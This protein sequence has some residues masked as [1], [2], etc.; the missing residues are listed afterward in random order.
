M[1]KIEYKAL[2]NLV[3]DYRT[4]FVKLEK[5]MARLNHKIDEDR[6]VIYYYENRTRALSKELKE[7]Y[8]K[9]VIKK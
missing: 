9:Y 1:N 6:Q 3:N 2:I 5:E 4:K 8:G 7:V